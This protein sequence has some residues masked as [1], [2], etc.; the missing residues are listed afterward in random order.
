MDIWI[1]SIIL[2][3]WIMLL[4][5]FTYKFLF[6]DLFSILLGI[7]LEVELLGHMVTI[8]VPIF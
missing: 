5:I 8:N 4:W 3:L 1:V 7:Y 6:E 2:L